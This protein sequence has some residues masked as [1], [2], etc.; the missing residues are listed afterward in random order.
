MKISIKQGYETVIPKVVN[1]KTYFNQK[2]Y[3]DF[4]GPYPVE[5]LLSIDGPAQAYPIGDY[6]LDPSSYRVNQYGSL[7]INR[8]EI[9]L[10]P[11]KKAA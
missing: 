9:K 11:F 8:F 1:D 10:L 2:A 4:G 7:E 6:T 3:A 5:F